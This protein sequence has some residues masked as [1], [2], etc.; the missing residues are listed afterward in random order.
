MVDDRIKRQG[1]EKAPLEAG[2]W[3]DFPFTMPAGVQL[4]VEL[5]LRHLRAREHVQPFRGLPIGK[6]V[7]PAVLG[8]LQVSDADAAK[9]AKTEKRRGR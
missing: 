6:N 2:E 5:Y 1:A 9:S 4:P 7:H 3:G 8:E